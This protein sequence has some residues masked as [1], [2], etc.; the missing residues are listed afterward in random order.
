MRWTKGC[1]IKSVCYLR[2]P[3]F[4]ALDCSQGTMFCREC[5]IGCGSINGAS[6]CVRIQTAMP[7]VKEIKSRVFGQS[8]DTLICSGKLTGL[9]RAV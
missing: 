8:S 9:S 5:S 4:I 1:K 6:P 7:H 2:W 3:D